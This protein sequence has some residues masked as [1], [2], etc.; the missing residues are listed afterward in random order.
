METNNE[1]AKKDVKNEIE[2]KIVEVSPKQKLTTWLFIWGTSGI[3]TVLGIIL[4]CSYEASNL[5][6]II[7]TILVALVHAYALITAKEIV[8]NEKAAADEEK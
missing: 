5:R 3:T 1:N 6:V 8:E 2:K 4:L 7:S